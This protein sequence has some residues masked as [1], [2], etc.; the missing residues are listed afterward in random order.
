MC[1]SKTKIKVIV[2]MLILALALLSSLVGTRYVG[3]DLN[4]V[5]NLSNITRGGDLSKLNSLGSCS[6]CS[7]NTTGGKMEIGLA[8][9]AAVYCKEMGY[10]YRIVKT[11]DGER[12]VVVLPNGKQCDEWAFYRGECG[13]EFSYCARRGWLV[14]A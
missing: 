5:G 4:S 10:E 11:G 9:P 14:S 1:C 12:G 13:Q 7:T 2:L 8:N 6:A 3:N